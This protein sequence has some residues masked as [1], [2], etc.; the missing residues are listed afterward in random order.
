MLEA[1]DEAWIVGSRHEARDTWHVRISGGET[2][3][4]TTLAAAADAAGG[5][6]A[7]L[8]LPAETD[9]AG[10]DTAPRGDILAYTLRCDVAST[11]LPPAGFNGTVT[12]SDGVETTELAREMRAG[13]RL[14][15]TLE[16]TYD[17]FTS[18]H[19]H[20]DPARPCFRSMDAWSTT[21][22]TSPGTDAFAGM[23]NFAGVRPG[24][25]LSLRPTGCSRTLAHP[26]V[27]SAAGT[28]PE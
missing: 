24:Y 28:C 25:R 22:G 27:T 5:L 26:T 14:S 13:E 15:E 16:G 7:G 6:L 21:A 23:T 11:V 12:W 10:T 3:R 19:V 20:G 8:T 1:N 18:G 9:C 2:G 17:G 4:G